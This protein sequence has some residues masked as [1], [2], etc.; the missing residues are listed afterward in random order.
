M[1]IEALGTPVPVSACRAIVS[2]FSRSAAEIGAGPC[3]SRSEAVSKTK[4]KAVR[5]FSGRGGRFMHDSSETGTV[6]GFGLAFCRATACYSESRVAVTTGSCRAA[7]GLDGRGRPSPHEQGTATL[8]P[9]SKGPPWTQ[10]Y[11]ILN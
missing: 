6:Y 3:A 4:I 5:R 9:I 2:T 11:R 8:N 1:A 10:T 7:L